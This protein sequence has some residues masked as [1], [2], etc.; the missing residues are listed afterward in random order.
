[1]SRSLRILH[2][3]SHNLIWVQVL[4]TLLHLIYNGVLKLAFLT[5]TPTDFFATDKHHYSAVV[6]NFP[7]FKVLF[8][9]SR[10]MN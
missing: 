7:K 10:V 1:M 6:Y 2:L 3:S 8:Q 4:T 5:K 9:E